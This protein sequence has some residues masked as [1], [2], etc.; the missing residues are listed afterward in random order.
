MAALHFHQGRQNQQRHTYRLA[1]QQ[2]WNNP[3]PFGWAT[4]I[5]LTSIGLAL[6]AGFVGA[7]LA[8]ATPVGFLLLFFGA[9]FLVFGGVLLLLGFIESIYHRLRRIEHHCGRCQFYRTLDDGYSLGRCQADPRQRVMQR[10]N[11]CQF[12][13]YSE[14]AMVRDRFAQQAEIIS[15][16]RGNTKIH[17]SL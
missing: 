7:E 17:S 9:P 15:R 2:S 10:T 4:G 3:D 11:G 8:N 16:R 6:L 12:F 5:M 1:L 14:R 13:E